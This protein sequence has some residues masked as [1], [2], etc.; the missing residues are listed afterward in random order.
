MVDV[1]RFNPEPLA[2]S[3]ASAPLDEAR[4][5]V[6]G[7]PLEVRV[8]GCRP[9]ASLAPGRIREASLSL[10][11]RSLVNRLE[12][13]VGEVFCDVGDAWG[14][15]REM[16][17][18]AAGLLS[19]AVGG[20]RGAV[21]L[22]GDHT[23]LYSVAVA[24]ERGAPTPT[25]VVLDA[26]LDVR[27]MHGGEELAPGTVVARLAERLGAGRVYVLGARSY[28]GVDEE[29]AEERGVWHAGLEALD[30]GAE[31]LLARVDG[32]EWLHISVDLDVLDPS[33]APGVSAPEP[34]GA[35]LWAVL[36]LIHRL[37]SAVDSP[38]TLDVV[39]YTPLYDCGGVTAYVAARI[40][41]EYAAA[42]LARG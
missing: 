15:R 21:L 38:V 29:R 32:A 31:E 36:R 2:F 27:A 24:A 3:G 25:V 34:P 14:S 8:P 42:L 11:P 33:I 22:G 6:G 35:S 12:L 7:V 39:E 13:R 4:I 20:G 17:G 10:T 23:I 26:H 30:G 16:L 41:Y 37:V 5:L 40:V 18:A 1:L 28:T 19:R 9:G